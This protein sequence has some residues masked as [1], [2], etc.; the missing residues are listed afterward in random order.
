MGENT[1]IAWA[2]HSWSPWIGCTKVSSGCSSCYAE[3]QQDIKYHRVRWGKGQ[4]R[5][6]T[7]VNYW[8]QP[9][10]WEK[11][12]LEKGQSFRVFPSLCDP[13][14]EEILAEWRWDFFDLM[15]ATPH[16]DWLLL[17][18]RPEF[19][20]A[21]L[22]KAEG[23]PWPNVWLGVSVEDQMAA[24]YRIPILSE[25]P[26]IIKFISCE[27]LLNRLD[28]THHLEGI[29]W[30]IVGGESGD[31]YRKMYPAWSLNLFAQCQAAKVPFFCKQGSGLKSGCQYDLP[32][33]LW[34][35]KE[36]PYRRN[37]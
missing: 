20:A 29:N 3:A 11:E 25:I 19:A 18:K 13:F 37:N 36:F 28:L 22:P 33:G 12:A 8:K 15:K 16:L 5:A 27:P 14:D 35:V 10:K 24:D 26:A 30:V 34:D 7:S 31:D 21:Y 1:K 2:H 23:W 4:A 32:N 17:T 9:Y 6:R